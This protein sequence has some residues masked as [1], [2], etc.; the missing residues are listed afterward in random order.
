M[1][2]KMNR[3]KFVTVSAAALVGS[4]VA[5]AVTPMPHRQLGRTGV[6]VRILGMGGIGF[7][8]DW[9]NQEEIT[10]LIIECLDAGVNYID[11]AHTYGDGKSERSLGLV[12][13]TKRRKEVFLATKT[14]NRTYEGALREVDESLKR[15]RTDHL[16][17]IQVHG[18]G[19]EQDDVAA[20]GRRNGVLP[21]LQKLQHEKV[22]RFIGIT[23]HPTQP[24]L[25]EAI[26][27]YDFDTLLCFVNPRA[28]CRWV[29]NELYPIAQHKKLGIIAMKTFGG[30][31]PAALV[32][33]GSG[34]EPAALLLRYAFSQ[35]IAVA[36]PSVASSEEFRQNL[37]ATRSF[38][39]LSGPERR[40]LIARVN[41]APETRA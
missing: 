6:K 40:A 20:I 37:V 17:L 2:T 30:G 3:R 21:A 1:S 36:V 4:A 14:A 31:K 33:E 8:T 34:R 35:P 7:L 13:G 19:N 12:M 24:K 26:T 29:E 23:G 41:S 9:D 22:V 39:P 27:T 32:G 10:A 25:K 38:K 18:F 11:T 15:L 16:D 28:E 5:G